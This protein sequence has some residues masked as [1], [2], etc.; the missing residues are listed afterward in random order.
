MCPERPTF[1]A[2]MA[3]FQLLLW[4]YRPRTTASGDVI[5]SVVRG[6]NNTTTLITTATTAV[7]TATGTF[8]ASALLMLL[9][10]LVYNCTVNATVVRNTTT[11]LL[12]YC[13]VVY[14]KTN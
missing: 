9:Q 7:A 1:L 4:R 8:N 3:L 5:H 10:C 2:P 11:V 6:T 12:D 14:I 13:A